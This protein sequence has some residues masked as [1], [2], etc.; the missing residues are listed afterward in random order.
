LPT[1]AEL[2]DAVNQF[3]YPFPPTLLCKPDYWCRTISVWC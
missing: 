2:N 3:F 1:V